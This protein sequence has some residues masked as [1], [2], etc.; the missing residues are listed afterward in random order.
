MTDATSIAALR[1][2]AEAAVKS[3]RLQQRAGDVADLSPHEVQHLVHELSV[4]QVELEMQNEELRRTQAALSVSRDRYADLYNLAPVGTFTLDESGLILDVN[5]TGRRL[6][7]E[8]NAL[9]LNAPFIRH[10]HPAERDRVHTWHRQ[11]LRSNDAPTILKTRMIRLAGAPF[12]VQIVAAPVPEHPTSW[13]L[14]VADIEAITQAED[15]FRLVF[16]HVPDGV[17]LSDTTSRQLVLVNPAMCA[18]LGCTEAEALTLHLADLHPP[19]HLRQLERTI[20]RQLA[21]GPRLAEVIPARRRDETTFPAELLV[22]GATLGGRPM[23]LTCLRD[24]SEKQRLLSELAQAD[25]LASM[26]LLAAGIAHELNNPLSYVLYNIESLA[27]DLPAMARAMTH[28]IN[29]L[30]SQLGTHASAPLLAE[31]LAAITPT[32]LTDAD[33]RLRDA[34]DGIRRIVAITRNLGRFTRSDHTPPTPIRVNDSVEQAL[35]IA[36]HALKP[37]A[38]IVTDLA[39]S[40]RVLAREGEL[41]Q[42]FLN[43]LI[44]ASHA[45]EGSAAT[46]NEVSVRTWVERDQVCIE[47]RDTGCGIPAEDQLRVFEPFFTTKPVGVGSGLG[48]SISSKLVAEFGGTISVTSA[49][50]QG[51]SFVVKLPRVEDTPAPE[52]LP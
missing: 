51:T 13:R 41:T 1:A 15:R 39:A 27:E 19:T 29:T 32:A 37:R 46:E 21:E 11:L 2:T 17:A 16:D 12:H 9:L 14:A 23:L 33:D 40:P 3:A 30:T 49:V 44:N 8:S 4:Y 31:A 48:L 28:C 10:V 45:L 36:S 26:G 25:R 6:L 7:G 35:S 5:L 47:V 42:I 22:T 24:V 18:M 34:V 43:L 50:G 38:R 52:P 20:A